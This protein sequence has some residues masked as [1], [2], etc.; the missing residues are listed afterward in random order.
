MGKR[1]YREKAIDLP[2]KDPWPE[3]PFFS[4]FLCISLSLGHHLSLFSL[5]LGLL[6]LTLSVCW[7]VTKEG[8]GKRR[9]EKEKK[10]E[11]EVGVVRA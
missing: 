3:N 2:H 10:R 8:E 11:G 9:E 7:C 5:N 1:K 6:S 4:S